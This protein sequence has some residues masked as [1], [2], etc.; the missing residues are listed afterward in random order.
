MRSQK[1]FVEDRPIL[2]LVATPI[3][4]L[5]DF[6]KR[7]IDTLQDVEVIFAEDTRTSGK[8]LK[9]YNINTPLKS[10]HKFNES[11]Q[12]KEV[13]DMMKKHH[14]VAL[15]SDAGSPL[16]SDPG[17]SLV[18]AVK[19][20]GYHISTIPGP[21]ALISA[22]TISEIVTHPFIFFGFLPQKNTERKKALNLLK[23][24]PYT[25]IFY[26][27]P[28]RLSKTLSSLFEYF[29][30]R[31]VTIAREM[32]KMYE[33]IIETTLDEVSE[34]PLELKGEIVLIVEGAQK[35]ISL[36][37]DDMIEHVQLLLEDGFSEMEA[38]KKVAKA[39]KLK[40]NTVYMAY[41]TYKKRTTNDI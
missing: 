17:E 31:K 1:T 39:R 32:T 35:D 12:I 25:L 16:I 23:T 6:S 24:L 11:T 29:G 18:K 4:H 27:A 19:N 15:I 5:D 36:S 38:I 13:V 30:S 9:H 20:E 40:K 21:T 22:V 2:Y 7:A 14:K 34:K 41:Q 28:H 26:E 8:L 10:F 3:G 33:E 37:E